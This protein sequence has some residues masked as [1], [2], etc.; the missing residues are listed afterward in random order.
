M[1]Q[2]DLDFELREHD[3]SKT[4]KE[5]VRK[6]RRKYGRHPPPRFQEWYKFARKRQVHNV[7]DFDQIWDDLRPFWAVSPYVIRHYAAHASD[8]R[9]HGT[10]VVSLRDGQ[11]FQ[12]LWGWRSETFTKMLSRIGRWLPDMDIPINRMDQPRV[13]VPWEEMQDMLRAEEQSRSLEETAVTDRFT[14]NMSG[15]WERKPPPPEGSWLYHWNPFWYPVEHVEDPDDPVPDYGWFWYAGRQY[16]D[17]AAKAC[18]PESY[19][20]NVNSMTHLSEAEASYKHELGG[21]VTNFNRSS[22]LCT[23][24]PQLSGLHGMLFASSS[25]LATQKLVP[26]FGECK[27][28]VNNEILFP[29]NMYWRHD[30]RY[31]YDDSQDISWDDKE[32]MMPW[33]GVT[34]GGTAFEDK[35]ELWRPM[36]R[37]RL[38]MLTNASELAGKTTAILTLVNGDQGT[39]HSHSFEPA[40]FASKHTDVGFSAKI[41]CIPNCDFYD[42]TF[43]VLEPTTFAQTF[44]SKYLIDVDGHSFSGRWR[45][46]LQS[47]SLGIK[48]TIFREWHDSRLWAW[49]HFVPMDNRF[50]ELYSLLTYFIGYPSESTPAMSQAGFSVPSTNHDL[51]VPRHDY[52]AYKIAK[53]GRQWAAKVLRRED[54]EIYLFRLLL[55]YGRIIDDNRDKIGFVGD[56]GKE[57]E[58]FDR[59]VPAEE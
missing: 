1:Q 39:Y 5:T 23:V 58:D 30:K 50:N 38:V 36:H 44:A 32:D 14:K 34:S 51:E 18:P 4:F 6:Y 20:R 12:E 31:E 37:Q 59:R 40:D 46:F 49:R 55:E 2:A 41:A 53:Q 22:D 26:L 56:G 10:A 8:I 47:R 19:A 9:D 17:L 11:V 13:V 29:A 54:I 21:F 52:E 7:D 35:P 43:R 45:A 33:R 15:F 16:M 48:S 25:T 24:G 27:L 57:M 28:N 42:E 3:R